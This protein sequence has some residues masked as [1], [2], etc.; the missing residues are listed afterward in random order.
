M[1]GKPKLR[2]GD[3]DRPCASAGDRV[4]EIVGEAGLLVLSVCV[5]VALSVCVSLSTFGGCNGGCFSVSDGRRFCICSLSLSRSGCLGGS[6]LSSASL[7]LSRSLSLSLSRSRFLS[8][9]AFS[10]ILPSGECPLPVLEPLVSLALRFIV[11]GKPADR[12]SRDTD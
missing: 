9:N 10:F 6:R 5:C 11:T 7:L 12:G 3:T 2:V 1:K 4:G 8:L